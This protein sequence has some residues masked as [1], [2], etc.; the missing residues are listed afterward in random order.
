MIPSESRELLTAYRRGH[1]VNTEREQRQLAHRLAAS[2]GHLAVRQGASVECARCGA[3]GT[4]H[5]V[6]SGTVHTTECAS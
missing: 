1:G 5:E 2:L 6:L 4:A 3:S